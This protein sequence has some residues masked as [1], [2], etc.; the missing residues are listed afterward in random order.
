MIKLGIESNGDIMKIK[1]EDEYNIKNFFENINRAGIKYVLIKNISNELPC[2]LIIG[3][4]IDIL[5]C[6]SDKDKFNFFMKS[7]GRKVN[8]PYNRYNGWTN[9][10][11]LPEFEFWRL[12]RGS[13]LL[14]DVTYKLCCKGLMPKTWIPLDNLIQENAWANRWWNEDLLCWQ[15]DIDTSYVYYIVRCIFDKKEFLDRYIFEIEKISEKI[16]ESKVDKMLN[17]V[18]N[19]FTP[20]L[21]EMLQEKKYEEINQA[22]LRFESY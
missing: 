17:C 4:D 7:Q 9:L 15:L 16:D 18:F 21:K 3:K 5:V 12:Y 6:S 11:G 13:D 10:Y 20:K 14:I 1:Y 19:K 22:Y 8:H 2:K